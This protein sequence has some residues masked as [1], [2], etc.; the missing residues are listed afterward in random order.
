MVVKYAGFVV[1]FCRI[2]LEKHNPFH[3]FFI[4]LRNHLS[5]LASCGRVRF[6]I[7]VVIGFV[8]HLNW[9][10]TNIGLFFYLIVSHVGSVL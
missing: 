8:R 7:H 1:L 4:L 10:P 9:K 5:N 6:N 2:S 3:L